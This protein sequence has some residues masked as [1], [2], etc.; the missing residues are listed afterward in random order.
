MK[1]I[2]L[3]ETKNAYDAAKSG[4]ILPRVA[5]IKENN[6]VDYNPHHDYVEIAGIKWATMN[7]GANKVTDYGLY[8]QWG[9][10]QG[11]TKEEINQGKKAFDWSNYKFTTDG[12]K[13]FTKYNGTDGKTV[14]DLE[15]DAVHAAWGGS[16]RMPTKEEFLKLL[17][18]ANY[19]FIKMDGVNGLLCTDRKDKTKTLFFP[20]YGIA[21][22]GSIQFNG[23]QGYYLLSSLRT[24]DVS[25]A[26]IGYMGN[27]HLLNEYYRSYGFAVRGVLD[28]KITNSTAQ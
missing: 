27:N 16:W 19:S 20:T 26:F 4:L 8:F 15:D 28:D 21:I 14:L 18:A 6:V 23:T 10:T 17:N 5:Y 24:G 13:S 22:G 25:K 7:V 2:H 12:G 3:F 9:D 11:Y 1:N